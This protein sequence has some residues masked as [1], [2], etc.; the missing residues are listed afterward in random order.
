MNGKHFGNFGHKSHNIMQNTF[1]KMRLILLLLF[2]FQTAAVA[3][4]KIV[5]LKEVEKI[6]KSPSDQIQVVN[7]WATW[8]GPC[9]KEMPLF[10]SLEKQRS[11]VK[12]TLVS[13]DLDLDANP[14]KVFKFVERKGIQSTVLILDETDPNSWINKID[15]SW[16]GSLPA[17]IVV[18]TKTGKRKFV[19]RELKEGELETLIDSVK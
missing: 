9:I 12:V 14:E 6:L 3:Q 19:G 13:L 1:T 8:C 15:K 18:N 11:D 7:F 5:K 4:P 17:T 2:F 16:S 10:E